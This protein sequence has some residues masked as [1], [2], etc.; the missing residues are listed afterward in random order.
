MQQLL[1]P[2]IYHALML[3]ILLSI[4]LVGLLRVYVRHVLLFNR[5]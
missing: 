5:G 4:L 1:V 2:I 3:S